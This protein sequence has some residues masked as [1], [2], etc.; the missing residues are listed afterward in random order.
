MNELI[1]NF[2]FSDI[3][4][5]LEVILN[6]IHPSGMLCIEKVR[7]VMINEYCNDIEPYRFA[8]NLIAFGPYDVIRIGAQIPF[9]NIDVLVIDGELVPVQMR[10]PLPSRTF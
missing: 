7:I 10:D 6:Y 4:Y 1:L 2:I 5:L 8:L 3:N 9:S